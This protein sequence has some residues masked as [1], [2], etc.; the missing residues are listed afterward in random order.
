MWLVVCR[1]EINSLLIK[2]T[3]VGLNLRV[4]SSNK[5][6]NKTKKV[7]SYRVKLNFN[8]MRAI[9]D[10]KL[11][12]QLALKTFGYNQLNRRKTFRVF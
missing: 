9:F 3:K 11:V 12:K 2:L 5:K 6:L 4:I 8:T 10:T 1:F 7:M